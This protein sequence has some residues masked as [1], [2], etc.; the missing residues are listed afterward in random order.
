MKNMEEEKL[1]IYRSV[2]E[3]ALDHSRYKKI[4]VHI[5]EC[6]ED[7]LQS[8]QASEFWQDNSVES[9]K[10]ENLRLRSKLSQLEQRCEI[11]KRKE[12]YLAK[13]VGIM[14]ASAE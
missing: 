10:S 9:E 11:L 3:R 14:K 5:R 8:R 12:V 13:R 4:L 7:F 2:F 1:A 6:Y